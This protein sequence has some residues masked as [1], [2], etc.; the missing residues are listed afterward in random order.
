M[1]LNDVSMWDRCVIYA[2]ELF[3]QSFARLRESGG[4][5]VHSVTVEVHNR[6]VSHR[7]EFILTRD[8]DENFLSRLA[9]D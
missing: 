8:D 6:D 5:N 7:S 2:D 4:R 1:E 3:G 9:A